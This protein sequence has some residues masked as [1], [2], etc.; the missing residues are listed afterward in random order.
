MIIVTG[1][2]RGLGQAIVDRLRAQGETVLALSRTGG[3]PGDP[4]HLACDVCDPASLKDV[5]RSL[6]RGDKPLTAVIAAAGIAKMNL[7]LTTPADTVRSLIETNLMGTIFTCQAFAPLMIRNKKGRIITFSTIAV[8]LALEGESV[9]AASKAGVE[10]FSRTF[11]REV[12][13]AGITV[14]CIAPGPIRTDLLRGVSDAQIEAITARQI[15]R[16]TAEPGDVADLVELLLSDKAGSIT[17][18][19]LHVK[20]V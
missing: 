6:R 10:S 20:G 5:A 17:G 7:A 8:P 2:G 9:Y 11:A 1:G 3:G 4:D 15:N 13:E 19:I 14:N 12:A 16:Q 18:E